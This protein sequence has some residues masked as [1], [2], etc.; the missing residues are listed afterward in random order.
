MFNLNNVILC[1]LMISILFIT[2]V[3]IASD[4]SGQWCWDQDSSISAFC[5]NITKT[6]RTY[7]G[8]YGS[9][10]MSGN[11]IDDNDNAFH[12]NITNEAI[13]QTKLKAGITGNLGIIQLHIIDNKQLEWRILRVP[14][15]EIY[16]PKK[17][18]LHR[19]KQK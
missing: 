7:N 13:V 10:I 2:K 18:T 1:I 19:C 5:L 6:N 9:V 17:A 12:F 8:G 3:T 14:K 15:G 16:I 11:I 4:F